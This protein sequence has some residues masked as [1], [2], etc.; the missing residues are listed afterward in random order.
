[1]DE[2][3]KAEKDFLWELFPG[4]E[5]PFVDLETCVE[6]QIEIAIYALTEIIANFYDRDVRER[7]GYEL[8][9]MTNV[10]NVLKMAKRIISIIHRKHHDRKRSKKRVRAVTA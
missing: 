10:L 5:M 4:G 1:M 7:I 2:I 3:R 6:S 8:E 9:V